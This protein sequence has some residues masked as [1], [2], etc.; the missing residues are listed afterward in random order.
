MAK[1]C[2]GLTHCVSTTGQ[3]S[4][5]QSG[6]STL[7]G[8]PCTPHRSG[9]GYEHKESSV[10]APCSPFQL[11]KNRDTAFIEGLVNEHIHIG[12]ATFNVYKLLGIHEQNSLID[13]T[14][15]GSPIT[16]GDQ[17]SFPATQAFDKFITEWRSIQQGDGVVLS[18]FLGYD[19]G[20]LKTNDRSR[21]AYGVDTSIF[22]HITAIA[23]KQSGNPNRRITSAR[24]ERS[25]DGKKWYGVAIL[26]IPDNDCL[27]T[28]TFRSS[29]PS[30]YW[31]IR[32]L[33][34]TGIVDNNTWGVQALQLFHN[35]E[36]THVGNVQ[37]KILLEN[38][39][40]DYSKE[41]MAIKGVYDLL[42]I[43][44]ELTRFGIEV[45]SLS[46]YMQVAFSA[47]IAALGRPIIIGDII[48]IP[49]EAQYSAEMNIVERWI[50]VVDIAWSTEGYTPGW[51]PTMLRIIGQP[52]YVSQETQDI[53]GDL[54]ATKIDDEHGLV[55]GEDGNSVLFQDY[56]DVGQTIQAEAKDAVPERGVESSSVIRAWETDEIKV[57]AESGVNLERTGQSSNATYQEDAIP[58]NN[59]PYTES[60]SY[61]P[62]PAHGDYH[63]MTYIGLAEEVPSRL[64]RYSSVKGRW[65]FL[66]KDRRWE[67]NESPRVLQDFLTAGTEKRNDDDIFRDRLM[68]DDDCE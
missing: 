28:I 2:N 37:D 58:P 67:M 3:L 13:C 14:G 47:C 4:L 43:T 52:A 59:A 26:N 16:N 18:S 5:A 38:R 30:R 66:E 53:F 24:V 68:I 55:D 64:F 31:R 29:V 48:E 21:N 9:K 61:P 1:D 36:E 19:F 56:F 27:N 57:A 60:A 39:D 65:I 45:P 7:D 41:P 50:E 51:A 8:N 42:D 33:S 23:I 35:Y 63:R 32:P 49:S 54:A 12:G 17:P 62:S 25:T 11:D 40:R 34:F 15:L 20:E 6:D 22:R 46:L 10:V 44:S